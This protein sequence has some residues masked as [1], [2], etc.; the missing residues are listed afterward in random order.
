MQSSEPSIEKITLHGELLIIAVG[1][2]GTAIG[3]LFSWQTERL[4]YRLIFGGAC[5]IILVLSA[6]IFAFIS[7][8]IFASANIEDGS[9]SLVS[10]ILYVGGMISSGFS[11]I[12]TETNL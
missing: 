4:H 10:V 7:T 1:M 6:L 3:E 11:T 9:I 12:I 2:T 5:T 8:S